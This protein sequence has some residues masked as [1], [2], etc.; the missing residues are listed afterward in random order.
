[1]QRNVTGKTTSIIVGGK[2]RRVLVK[3]LDLA[4]V[5]SGVSAHTF[6]DNEIGWSKATA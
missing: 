1:M 2:T 3:S 5:T 6:T 4:R